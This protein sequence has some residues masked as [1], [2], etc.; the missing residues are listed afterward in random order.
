MKGQHQIRDV[1][2][3]QVIDMIWNFK[4]TDF[5][6]LCQKKKSVSLL[7]INC[8]VVWYIVE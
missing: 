4:S 6:M 8:D 3:I 5:F 7:I 1:K 2:S